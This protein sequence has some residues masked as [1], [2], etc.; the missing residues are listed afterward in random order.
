VSHTT[1][2]R[3]VPR[4]S[5]FPKGRRLTVFELDGIP[6]FNQDTEQN[7]PEKSC[8]IEAA[9]ARGRCNSIRDAGIQLLY[10]WS[11]EERD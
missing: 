9:C 8:G 6:G 7:P 10:P 1:V 3:Y 2:R 5:S 4:R 11:I